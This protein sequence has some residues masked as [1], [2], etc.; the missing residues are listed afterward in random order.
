MVNGYLPGTPCSQPPL[1]ECSSW[2]SESCPCMAITR[3]NICL[4]CPRRLLR[5]P[6][7]TWHQ[8]YKPC[9]VQTQIFYPQRNLSSK[10]DTATAGEHLSKDKGCGVT[11]FYSERYCSSTGRKEA[12]TLDSYGS[13]IDHCG[14]RKKLACP[15]LHPSSRNSS[16]T[17]DD[18]YRG[19]Q[20]NFVR[21]GAGAISKESQA[22]GQ[23]AQAN[24]KTIDLDEFWRKYMSQIFQMK[25]K[26]GKMS[27]MWMGTARGEDH[28]TGAPSG[29]RC[30]QCSRHHAKRV[31]GMKWLRSH[32]SVI[33]V[34]EDTAVSLL[35]S[36]AKLF[37]IQPR[38]RHRTA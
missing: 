14:L 17:F 7:G 27:R 32:Q 2:L 35:S 6:S 30:K 8:R 26:A 29:G 23:E 15:L 28:E 3:N 24:D 36:A 19:H 5:D 18:E 25:N 22:S 11:S 21:H 37:P 20:K 4:N 33:A 10:V 1:W 13:T 12:G 34:T 38:G 31:P 9:R 16:A